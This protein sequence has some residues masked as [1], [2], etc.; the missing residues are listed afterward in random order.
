MQRL[1]GKSLH[2]YRTQWQSIMYFFLLAAK[3]RCHCQCLC[4]ILTLVVRA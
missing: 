1:E 2:C 4:I 3:V